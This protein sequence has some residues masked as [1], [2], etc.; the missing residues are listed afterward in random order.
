VGGSSG[1]RRGTS[2][3]RDSGRD[4]V[5][6]T[7][8]LGRIEPPPFDGWAELVAWKHAYDRYGAGFF[9]TREPTP[10]AEATA[11]L[12]ESTWGHGSGRQ[13]TD[14][15]IQEAASVAVRFADIAPFDQRMPPARWD[16]LI[17]ALNE[18]PHPMSA[19]V[20]FLVPV[21]RNLMSECGTRET[22]EQLWAT[23]NQE[24]DRLRDLTLHTL[25]P[26][27]HRE[28][29][30]YSI[31]D[32]ETTTAAPPKSRGALYRWQILA[33]IW[34]RP[35]R[36][37]Y[38]QG[39]CISPE[40]RIA[41]GRVNALC[42]FC[43]ALLE[44]EASKSSAIRTCSFLQEF[45]VQESQDPNRVLP[46]RQRL[47]NALVVLHEAIRRQLAKRA[48]V[49]L[50]EVHL[51]DYESLLRDVKGISASRRT[52]DGQLQQY[53]ELTGLTVSELSDRL[54]GR[55]FDGLRPSEIA[56]LLMSGMHN[57][58]LTHPQS[59]QAAIAEA[60]KTSLLASGRSPA[61]RRGRPPKHI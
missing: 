24:T 41:A 43:C 13:L 59:I 14:S 55:S 52:L 44:H 21:L 60:R 50:G 40:P 3:S 27:F 47:R 30:A 23:W 20:R 53:A 12:T 48:P 51:M 11:A 5:V 45:I 39:W 26:R 18:Y 7:V 32:F 2:R 10:S 25:S 61:R 33:H 34:Q 54:R 56:A 28:C 6:F 38:K 4:P 16:L 17:E 37:E 8:A 36:W 49:R 57:L 42:R 31:L 1:K 9:A 58:G 29:H 46:E 19:A 35:H 15:T 22:P